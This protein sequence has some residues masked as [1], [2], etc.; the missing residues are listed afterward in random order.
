MLIICAWCRKVI[1]GS[2]D[3]I[4]HGICSN[5]KEKL[6]KQYYKKIELMYAIEEKENY[7]KSR[8]ANLEKQI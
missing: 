7:R 6:M 5:C 1:K 3:V 8:K 4:S 2:G